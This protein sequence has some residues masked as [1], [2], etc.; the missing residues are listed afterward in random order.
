MREPSRLSECG[1]IMITSDKPQPQ[2]I[3]KPQYTKTEECQWEPDALLC[4]RYVVQLCNF[5]KIHGGSSR[6]EID[7]ENT[8]QQE[9]GTTHKHE[10]QFHGCV[11]FA[12]RTPYTNQQV[13]RNQCDF[14]EHEHGEQVDGY[15]ESEHSHREQGEPKEIF[16]GQRLQ[17]P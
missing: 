11:F 9:G 4:K 1:H 12:S 5:E 10:C 3:T 14:V 15:K 16:F 13:H 2:F 17:T 8:D 6:T 7:S